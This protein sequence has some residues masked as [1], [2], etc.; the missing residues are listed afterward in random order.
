MRTLRGICG[1]L[2]VASVLAL[3]SIARAQGGW[4]PGQ[5][6]P[7]PSLRDLNLPSLDGAGLPTISQTPGGFSILFPGG[8]SIV[9]ND[10]S[11]T[12]TWPQPAQPQPQPTQ[13]SW[14]TWPTQPT[15]P[16][17]PTPTAPM[18]STQPPMQGGR[19]VGVFGGITNY[20]SG[21]DLEHCADDATNMA[22][23]FIRAGII[24][25]N[26]ALVLTDGQATRANI[27][28]ALQQMA[29]RAGQ[30]GTVVF[31]FSGHGDHQADTNGDEMDGQDESIVLYD[32][33]LNDDELAGYLAAS[34]A[35]DF[36]GLDTCFAGGFQQDLQ[37]VASS[38]GFYSS[39]ENETS[40]IASEFG[41]GGY[42]SHFLRTGIEQSA[43]RPIQV[44]QLQQHVQ[45]GFMTS[46]AAG[47]Q[48]LVV[49]M[50]PGTDQSTTLFPNGATGYTI[51]SAYAMR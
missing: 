37:R 12:F 16:T 30:N 38:V 49:G 43:G 2:V 14:P 31:F 19:V 29:A 15:E 51:P 27:V 41:A 11:G 48:Q 3:P 47:R 24:A 10:P 44:A 4:N 45:Q 36:V 28:N 35:R 7:I 6:L 17:W 9:V 32:G 46:G 5:S 25:P 39:G 40:S 23:A 26:D 34:P 1:V 22:N 8:T 42:L 20:P 13:P 50:G 21:N 18:P 33:E